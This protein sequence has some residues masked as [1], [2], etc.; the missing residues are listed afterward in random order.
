M[1]AFETLKYT[2]FLDEDTNRNDI[3]TLV[4]RTF[5]RDFREKSVAHSSWPP[6][7]LE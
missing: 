1:T 3:L 4:F 6:K 5:C 7:L 2:F